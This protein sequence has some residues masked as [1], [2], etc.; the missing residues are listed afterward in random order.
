M[1]CNLA[2]FYDIE[3]IEVVYF[4]VFGYLNSYINLNPRTLLVVYIFRK[5][6]INL[7][8]LSKIIEQASQYR[9]LD[10]FI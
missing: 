4:M 9:R 2:M 5:R 6:P 3:D 10:N 8:N 7:F 1:F